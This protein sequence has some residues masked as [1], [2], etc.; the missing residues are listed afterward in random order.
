MEEPAA[1]VWRRGGLLCVGWEVG[2]RWIACRTGLVWCGLLGGSLA[3]AFGGGRERCCA[4]QVGRGVWLWDSW[5]GAGRG[6]AM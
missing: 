2:W 6:S 5:I 4:V 1:V 3:G